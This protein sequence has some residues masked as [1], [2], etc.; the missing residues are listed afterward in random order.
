MVVGLLD[1]K[2]YVKE[3]PFALFRKVLGHSFK[4]FVVQVQYNY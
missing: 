4:Y 2:K 3:L 1:P